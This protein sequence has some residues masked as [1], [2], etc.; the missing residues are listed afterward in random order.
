MELSKDNNDADLY[1]EAEVRNP[2]R[3]RNPRFSVTKRGGS[4]EK[5]SRWKPSYMSRK[6]NQR[7]TAKATQ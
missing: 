4:A 3:N 1:R 5:D 2:R 7:V 6:H